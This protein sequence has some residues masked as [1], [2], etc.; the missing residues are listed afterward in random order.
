MLKKGLTYT[1]HIVVSNENTARTLGSG[2]MDVLATPALVALMENAAMLCAA[3]HIPEGKTTVGSMIST[4]HLK[5]SAI[6]A[7]I[8]GTAELVEVDGRK[9]TFKV[10]ATEK[11]QIIGGGTHVRHIV[12]RKRFL[13]KL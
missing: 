13:E 7:M 8:V 12:D 9:L 2:D 4:S 3:P 11:G 10:I 6:G 1:S 5:P